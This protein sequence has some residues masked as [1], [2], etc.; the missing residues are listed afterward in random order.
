MYFIATP[1]CLIGMG[2]KYMPVEAQIEV[3]FGEFSPRFI[4]GG[5]VGGSLL[6]DLS[7]ANRYMIPIGD[8]VM[9]VGPM[10]DLK[11]RFEA[12]A[13]GVSVCSVL[14]RDSILNSLGVT[15]NE[16]RA[17]RLAVVFPLPRRELQLNDTCKAV[18]EG[19]DV[20]IGCQKIPITKIRELLALIDN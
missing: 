10:N 8:P 12:Y 1:R 5:A 6:S 18:V 17:N 14:M 9:W 13:P 20:I 2:L 11:A 19:D 16:S 7:T 3:G 15:I 4:A